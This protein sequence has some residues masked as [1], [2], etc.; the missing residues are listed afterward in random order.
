MRTPI[1]A[2]LQLPR[3]IG[4]ALAGVVSL[5]L[6]GC[7]TLRS[8]LRGYEL[9]PNGI[10]RTQLRLREALVQGD[11][12]T[13]LAWR[14][15]DALMRALTTGISTYY[16]AQYARSAAVLDS[17]ALLADDR[18]TASVSKDALALVSNDLARPYQPRRVERLFIPYYGM[19]GY[20]Q[21]GEWEEAAV[22]ARRIES[23]LA[24]Y[25]ADR[26]GVERP[27]HA[28]MHYL[29]GTVLERAAQRADAGVAYRAARALGGGSL[30]TAMARARGQGDVVVV[31]ER[32]F[33]AHRA[34]E[35]INLFLGDDRDSLRA[36]E[37][38]RGRAA[39]RIAGRMSGNSAPASV[40]VSSESAPVPMGEGRRGRHHGDDDDDDG[41][42]LAVA[43]PSLRRSPRPWGS[44]T[45]VRLDGRDGGH[46]LVRLDARVDD[47]AGA[48]ERRERAGLLA[49]AIGRATAKYA[50]TKAVKDR[51]GEVAGTIANVG[52]SLLE[53]AD[54]RSWHLLPQEI[55]VLR[56][57]TPAG[58]HELSL[59]I[60]DGPDR[61]LVSLGSVT[62]QPGTVAVRALRLWRDPAA[63]TFVAQRSTSDSLA[64]SAR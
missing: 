62:V 20:V 27:L 48:D 53:R 11:F 32:G 35:T 41:Y 1:C 57:R 18:I 34:T 4:L 56:V 9:G 45:T 16:A 59:E 29:A 14:E 42:W 6:G 13:A 28:A 26:D 36:G 64:A 12:P 49:R 52:G 50:I 22:E 17:A 38:E 37:R 24:Q 30:D 23:L 33:V 46:E 31:L 5:A 43:F 15:D 10:T 61:R 51:K 63:V 7:A 19:L 25:D 58:T 2:T 21:L 60:G 3:R 39:V 40:G 55:T 8:T 44:E 54:V 47:A